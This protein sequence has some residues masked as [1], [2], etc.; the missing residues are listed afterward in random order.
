M[1]GEL[2]HHRKREFELF[3]GGLHG[4]SGERLFQLD[5]LGYRIGGTAAERARS[6]PRRASG[7]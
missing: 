4:S 2:E 6:G 7:Q 5:Q 1:R 3:F